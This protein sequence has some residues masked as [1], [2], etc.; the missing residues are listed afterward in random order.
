MAI[1]SKKK[2]KS[3]KL[4]QIRKIIEIGETLCYTYNV[5]INC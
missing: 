4:L 1:L 3:Y 5:R 2:L